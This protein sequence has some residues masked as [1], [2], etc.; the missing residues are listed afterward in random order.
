[1]GLDSTHYKATLQKPEK[2]DPVH[3]PYI[4]ELE[5]EGFDVDVSYFSSYIQKIETAEILETLIFPKREEEIS[6]VTEFLKGA[7]RH[8]V[9]E[10]DASLMQQRMHEFLQKQGLADALLYRWETP[11]WTGFYAYQMKTETGFY[12]KEIGYQRK[13]MNAGFWKRFAS[14]TICCF[15]SKEDFEY[16]LSCV[17]F[18]WPADTQ[19]MVSNRKRLFKEQFVDAYEA[20]TSWLELSY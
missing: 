20:N 3:R 17:D 7:D 11:Q 12:T 5:F 18:Y 16:A 1:M 4:T 15:T 9:F 6:A 14:D 2:S 8:V 13:G 19:E 10:K